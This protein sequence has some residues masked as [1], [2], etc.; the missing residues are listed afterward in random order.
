MH[1]VPSDTECEVRVDAAWWFGVIAEWR[2]DEAGAWSAYVRHGS[3]DGNRIGLFSADRVRPSEG[4][5]RP[6]PTFG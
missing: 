1:V 6:K 2:R 4:D 5:Y 3:P